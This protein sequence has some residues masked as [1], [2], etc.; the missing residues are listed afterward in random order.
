MCSLIIKWKYVSK[1][2]VLNNNLTNQITLI[3]TKNDLQLKILNINYIHPKKK[4]LIR[5]NMYKRLSEY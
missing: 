3:T 1:T 5:K 2:I 4:S